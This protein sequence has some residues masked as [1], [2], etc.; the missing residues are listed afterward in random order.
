MNALDDGGNAL[1]N[2]N[3]HGRKP[4]AAPA[5]FHFVNER[6]HDPR[7]AA[8]ERMAESDSAAVDV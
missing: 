2:T 1:T 7:A 6:R 3:T 4:V 8:P 5:L